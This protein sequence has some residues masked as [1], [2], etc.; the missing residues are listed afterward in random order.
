MPVDLTRLTK[1][2]ETLKLRNERLA[3]Q[4][5]YLGERHPK[6]AKD[7][8]FYKM[9]MMFFYDRT[10]D[11][12]WVE[13]FKNKER[14]EQLKLLEYHITLF[15]LESDFSHWTEWDQLMEGEQHE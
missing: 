3:W 14:I 1:E 15:P 13:Y 9:I 2:I 6:N 10:I 4:T 8:F 7:S 5:R 11:K 12:L